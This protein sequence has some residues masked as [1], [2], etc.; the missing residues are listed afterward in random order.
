MICLPPGEA[1]DK[2]KHTEKAFQ[3]AENW[4]GLTKEFQQHLRGTQN[5]SHF[6]LC[7]LHL[8]VHITFGVFFAIRW[9][10]QCIQLIYL[11]YRSSICSV[12]Q[13]MAT[14]AKARLGQSQRPGI[15]SRILHEVWGSSASAITCC[16]PDTLAGSWI[17]N[18]RARIWTALWHGVYAWRV[19]T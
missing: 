9:E 11:K 3:T 7:H 12:T 19:L 1:Q 18:S 15:P 4:K 2:G 10:S 5:F 14:A 16:F 17:R 8:Y 13:Q 6:E